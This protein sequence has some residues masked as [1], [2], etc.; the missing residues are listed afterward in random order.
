M[1][2]VNQKLLTSQF[3]NALGAKVS[4]Q[5]TSTIEIVGVPRLH[6]GAHTIMPDRVEAGTYLVAAAVTGGGFTYAMWR[7]NTGC[8]TR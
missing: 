3:L 4:G 7:Q 5:G 8:S 1:Q 6:G 2:P